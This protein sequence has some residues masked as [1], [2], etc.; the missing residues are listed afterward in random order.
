LLEWIEEE[1]RERTERM[2][3]AAKALGVWR[4]MLR[5][6]SPRAFVSLRAIWKIGESTRWPHRNE[7][8]FTRVVKET[9]KLLA[10][11]FGKHKIAEQA[12]ER[13]QS[14]CEA[15][16]TIEAIEELHTARIEA[17]TEERAADSVSSV[18]F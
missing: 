18:F 1:P 15:G 13:A 7:E 2:P 14:Y 12:F 4:R 9:D 17:F 8:I 6:S 11:R 16:R 5:G 10:A 3:S